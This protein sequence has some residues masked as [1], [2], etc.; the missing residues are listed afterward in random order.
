MREELVYVRSG[1]FSGSAISL[2]DALKSRIDIVDLDLL[3]ISRR[4]DLLPARVTAAVERPRASPRAPRIK[5]AAWSR[6]IQRAGT[7]R[8]VLEGSRPLLIVQT[9]P[10]WVLPDRTRYGVYT[11][12]VGLEGAAAGGRFRSRFTRG[13]LERERAMLRGAHRVY[14]MGSSTRTALMDAYGVEDSRIRVVGA[15]P[16]ARLGPPVEPSSPRRL[17]FIGRQWDLKGGPE[18]LR[19][20]SAV[21]RA[22]PGLQL[23]LVGARPPGSLPGGV[24]SVGPV[25]LEDMDRIYS[26]SDLLAIPGHIE[27]FGISLVEGL[28]KGL[29]CIGT[30]VGNQ[31]EIIGRA[32]RC[33]RPGAVDELAAAIRDVVENYP[34]Y[35]RLAVERGRELRTTHSWGRVADMIVEDLIPWRGRSSDVTVAGGRPV[36]GSLEST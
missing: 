21:R 15:G 23:V 25:P 31:P 2:R 16:N 32:G 33:V 22:W 8:S 28:M 35:R 11:D 9:L 36:R 18:L 5:T 3:P 17:L 24:R 20:F 4:L 27:A 1:A 10:A 26:E 12:R 13:W 6:A 14:V 19:A 29:P 34:A 7:R 30:T